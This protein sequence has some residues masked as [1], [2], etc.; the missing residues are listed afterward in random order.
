[1]NKKIHRLDKPIKLLARR[2]LTGHDLI[3]SDVDLGK[4]SRSGALGLRLSD[5]ALRFH[6]GLFFLFESFIQRRLVNHRR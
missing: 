1:M 4:Q 6:H 3:G 2:F 5:L